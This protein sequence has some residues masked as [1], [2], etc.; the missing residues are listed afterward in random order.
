MVDYPPP[1]A[2]DDFGAPPPSTAIVQRCP[3]GAASCSLEAFG[4]VAR[5]GD[6]TGH[7]FASTEAPH[8]TLRSLDRG[9]VRMAPSHDALFIVWELSGHAH[10]RRA[11][12]EVLRRTASVPVPLWTVEIDWMKARRSAR[13]SVAFSGRMGA[14]GGI[15][16]DAFGVVRRFPAYASIEFPDDHLTVEHAPYKLMMTIE[17]DEDGQVVTRSRWI[18]VDVVVSEILL[19]HGPE[20]L[21]PEEPRR[22][23]L[24]YNR[25]N[26]RLW[27]RMASRLRRE[28]LDGMELIPIDL[29]GN[30]FGANAD[31]W[32]T[33]ASHQAWK[34]T[35]RAGPYVPLRASVSVTAFDDSSVSA[36]LALGGARFL[37]DWKGGALDATA[38]V[39][40]DQ[41]DFAIYHGN[42]RGDWPAGAQN[43]HSSCGGKRG[44]GSH[45]F[46]ADH[47]GWHD[48]FA[49]TEC[50]QRAGAAF[51]CAARRGEY[52]GC[53]GV[54]FWPS[55]IAR[56]AYQLT[57]YFAYGHPDEW[58]VDKTPEELEESVP[59]DLPKAK[60]GTFEVRHV[61]RVA[62][63]WTTHRNP[64]EAARLDWDKLADTYFAPV[65]IDL[66]LR[67]IEGGPVPVPDRHFR[68]SL[69][70]WMSARR[71]AAASAVAPLEEQAQE[72]Y[73]VKFVGFPVFCERVEE[74]CRSRKELVE[75]WCD[76]RKQLVMTTDGTGDAVAAMQARLEFYLEMVNPWGEPVRGLPAAPGGAGR[77]DRDEREKE[78]E[79]DGETEEGAEKERDVEEGARPD[80]GPRDFRWVPLS[81]RKA[82]RSAF[83]DQL[84]HYPDEVVDRVAPAI[85]EQVQAS[86][87][88]AGLGSKQLLAS[89]F[90]AVVGPDD[91]ARLARAVLELPDESAYPGQCAK[92]GEDAAT[93]VFRDLPAEED[94]EGLHLFQ[95][96]CADN[97]GGIPVSGRAFDAPSSR[98]SCP[99]CEQPLAKSDRAARKCPACSAVLRGDASIVTLIPWQYVGSFDLG[100][101]L[102]LKQKK[103][104]YLG[105]TLLGGG[106]P[107]IVVAHEMGHHLFM[108]HATYGFAW[109]GWGRWCVWPV[110]DLLAQRTKP[111]GS[112]AKF[113]SPHHFHCIMGYNVAEM[114]RLRFCYRCVMRLR[115]WN[116]KAVF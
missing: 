9:R 62:K 93:H 66:D 34:D 106:C 111:E 31:E 58:D 27:S 60:T 12:I 114:A 48:P 75:A 90:E 79:E 1:I 46:K 115:G 98:R 7:S 49:T 56:D 61:V 103:L 63:H 4:L 6:P 72:P 35:W 99:E 32:S 107:E 96:D 78:K 21:I 11:R 108:P 37:W 100:T 91:G 17:A 24:G 82:M 77:N 30:I 36:P 116:A 53:T 38:V 85:L 15:E 67:S 70:T 20:E 28:T 92:W 54:V 94:G 41:V 112:V 23:D 68:E 110:K 50:S 3:K 69:E 52:A 84:A 95:V 8:R 13:G 83:F 10:V 33:N 97:F 29:E 47:D 44:A 87:A 51:T 71:D 76:S 80:L 89:L 45:L 88:E 2:P 64:A 42:E 74:W 26:R 18:Y 39:K 104:Q 14:E 55:F 19:Y 22:E 5:P 109:E 16:E 113:H 43:T 102:E 105:G 57:V 65:G 86:F 73:A 101:M 81:A 25:R 40:E 59:A